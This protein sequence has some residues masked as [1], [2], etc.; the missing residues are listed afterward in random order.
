VY[1]AAGCH[2]GPRTHKRIKTHIY[3]HIYTKIQTSHTHTHTHTSDYST[4]KNKC[5][6]FTW[7][8]LFAAQERKNILPIF[9]VICWLTRRTKNGTEIREFPFSIRNPLY[10]PVSHP[11]LWVW[12]PFRLSRASVGQVYD[13]VHWINFHYTKLVE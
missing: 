7:V 1:S 10:F 13:L 6:P 4:L 8:S 11:L 5:L 2:H 9:C 3:P 12:L